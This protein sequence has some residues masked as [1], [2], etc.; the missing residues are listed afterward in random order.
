MD[1]LNFGY[2][3]ENWRQVLDLTGDHLRLSLATVALAL[4]FAIPLGVLAARFGRLTLPILGLLGAL[5]TVPSLAFLGFLVATPVGIGFDNALIVLTAYAQLFL[6]RNLVAGL[7][8][9]D[10][11]TVE[12][13]RGLGMTPWQL[14]RQVRWPLALPLFA[15]GLRTALVSTISLATVAAFIGAGG[16][17]RLLFDGLSLRRTPMILAGMV[18]IVAL[19]LLVDFL[20]RFL[21]RFTAVARANRAVR[22]A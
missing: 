8:G 20:V 16:L 22:R 7:R 1:D 12:A 13:A 4:V 6:V 15:A 19:A 9:A 18:A 2:L 11:A 3:I 21:E 5:Y 10:P 14:F 17:G